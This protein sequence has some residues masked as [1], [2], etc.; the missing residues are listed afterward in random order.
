M[1]M[2][3]VTLFSLLVSSNI[4]NVQSLPHGECPENKFTVLLS[5]LCLSGVKMQSPAHPLCQCWPGPLGSHSLPSHCTA[6]RKPKSSKGKTQKQERENPKAS[7]R[8]PESRKEKIQEQ[9]RENLRA[10]KRK[11]E[12]SKGKIQEQ[13]RENMRAAKRKSMGSDAA[14]APVSPEGL[15]GTL[16]RGRGGT[17]GSGHPPWCHS[18][19]CSCGVWNNPPVPSREQPLHC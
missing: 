18:Q 16:H 15:V 13:Q 9:Q 11:P 12:S 5:L 14:P 19:S 6:K 17:A 1:L 10:A 8:K 2:V 4:G 3:C 7:K